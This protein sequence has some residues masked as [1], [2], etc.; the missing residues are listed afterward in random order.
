MTQQFSRAAADKNQT[1]PLTGHRHRSRSEPSPNWVLLGRHHGDN[2]QLLALAEASGQPFITIQLH[3]RKRLSRLPGVLLGRSLLPLS[4]PVKWPERWPRAVIA[5]GRRAVPVARWIQGEAAKCGVAT[6]LI[7]IGRPR[8]PLRWFDL[9]ITTAQYGLPAL[10]NVV[11][12]LLP[13]RAK[14]EAVEVAPM[15]LVLSEQFARLRRPW[16]AVLVGGNSRPYYFDVESAS[17]LARTVDE[18]ARRNRGSVLVLGGPRTSSACLDELESKIEA[19][20]YVYRWQRGENPYAAVLRMADRF[21]VTGDSLA[22][23]GDALVTGKPVHLFELPKRLDRRARLAS[24]YQ[25]IAQR[26]EA[27]RGLYTS[28]LDAGLLF[29]LRDLSACQA[30]LREAGVFDRPLMAQALAARERRDTI[31]RLRATLGAPAVDATT[32]PP[33]RPVLMTDSTRQP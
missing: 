1:A 11:G 16:T 18:Q 3:F 33:P 20:H 5:S 13:L 28:L 2:R 15:P 19:P 30:R 24:F 27:V 25:R 8:C 9:V 7:H 10:D 32:P 6:R 17:K 26:W 22:M 31:A 23:L 21:V 14:D 29:S 4:Q 12:N